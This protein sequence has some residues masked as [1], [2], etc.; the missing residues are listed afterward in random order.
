VSRIGR[1]IRLSGAKLRELTF[2][3]R[4]VVSTWLVG[5]RDTARM[6]SRRR[7][8]IWL[9]VAALLVVGPLAFNLA[10]AAD[11]KASVRL[12]PSAV[13]PYPAP[14]DPGYYR[15]LLNDPVLHREMR[16]NVDFPDT[17]YDDIAIRPGTK[18][19]LL[20]L[21]VA[22]RT[23]ADAA[24]YVNALEV[25]IVVASQRQLAHMAAGDARDTRAQLQEGPPRAERRSLRRRLRRLMSLT[26]VDETLPPR[27]LPGAKA[28]EPAITRWADQVVD[29][30]PGSFHGRPSPIWSALAGLLVL[31]V[32]TAIALTFL[33]PRGRAPDRG[34]PQPD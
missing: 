25:Q 3:L 7:K 14:Q 13:S 9:G 33:P 18:R 19:G 21:A 29:D 6:Q 20:D 1:A 5:M 27:V 26:R 22:A 24:R 28:P 17:S 2:A 23:P 10:R 12:F 11:F 32:L 15:T 34:L 31:A 16:R 8:G 4:T 30:L